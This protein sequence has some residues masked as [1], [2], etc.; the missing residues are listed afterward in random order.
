MSRRVP[1]ADRVAAPSGVAGASACVPF[2]E[3]RGPCQLGVR[4][5][6]EGLMREDGLARLAAGRTRVRASKA[7]RPSIGP[8]AGACTK[9]GGGQPVLR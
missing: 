6:I 3:A 2:W 7:A 8:T 9:P 4:C 5:R 1:D